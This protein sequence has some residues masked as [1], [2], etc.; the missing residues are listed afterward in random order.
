MPL[1]SRSWSDSNCIWDPDSSDGLIC[2][3]ESYG[4]IGRSLDRSENKTLWTGLEV[5]PKLQ[6]LRKL[7]H[8]A[9]HAKVMSNQERSRD[10]FTLHRQLVTGS[11]PLKC[12]LDFSNRENNIGARRRP[13]VQSARNYRIERLLK[14]FKLCPVLCSTKIWR[15]WNR[16]DN[17]LRLL[18]VHSVVDGLKFLRHRRRCGRKYPEHLGKVLP[19]VE[20]HCAIEGGEIPR[21]GSVVR[22]AS[23]SH[24]LFV[25]FG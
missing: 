7:H 14:L 11:D 3:G 25:R 8:S 24:Q 23:F 12:I 20:L 9:G 16:G 10:I 5:R 15:H 19:P 1:P 21:K 22:S 6:W 13:G 2:V 4:A 18:H 17:R